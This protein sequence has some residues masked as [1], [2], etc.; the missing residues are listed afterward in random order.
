MHSTTTSMGCTGEVVSEKYSVS[1]AQQDEYAL[2][3]HRKAAAAIKAGYFR[4]EIVSVEIPQKKDRRLFSTLM[5][6]SART[7]HW[8]RS[9]N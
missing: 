5:R 4:D 8:R 1:R 7:H 3:S 9:A 2:N 6:Q